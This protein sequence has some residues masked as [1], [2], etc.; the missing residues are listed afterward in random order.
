MRSLEFGRPALRSTNT[1]ISAFI[2]ADGDL[3]QAGRQFEPEFL[4]GNLQ[5]RRG[6]TPYASS[7]NWP[8]IGLCMAI[9][10]LLWIRNRAS[11]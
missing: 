5:P 2:A 3:V 9:L 11:L 1:G 8:V 4:T 7:G 10:G 6:M